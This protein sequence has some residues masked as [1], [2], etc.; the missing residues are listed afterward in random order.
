[1]ITTNFDILNEL[2]S[3]QALTNLIVGE[4]Y[5]PANLLTNPEVEGFLPAVTNYQDEIVTP[6]VE[7]MSNRSR[8]HK[9][10]L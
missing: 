1:M 9:C 7:V 6:I 2:E 3:S 5:N 4:L 10:L 8:V